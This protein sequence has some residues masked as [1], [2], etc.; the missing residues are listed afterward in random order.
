MSIIYQVQMLTRLRNLIYSHGRE[1][2]LIAVDLTLHSTLLVVFFLVST[3]SDV[4]EP[5]FI[6][7]AVYLLMVT[8][9]NRYS[10]KFVRERSKEAVGPMSIT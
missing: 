2:L 1:R 10:H 3:G 6:A 7:M 5:I 4:G 9:L 8:T